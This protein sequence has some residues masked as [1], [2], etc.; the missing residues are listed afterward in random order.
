[1]I[2]LGLGV[3]ASGCRRTL[4]CPPRRTEKT[5]GPTYKQYMHG[6][7][8]LLAMSTSFWDECPLKNVRLGAVSS[9]NMDF[10]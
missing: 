4:S 1:M 3:W 5:C 10:L 6:H 8:C 2:V 9:G 7:V